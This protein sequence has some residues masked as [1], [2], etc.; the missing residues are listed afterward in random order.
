MSLIDILLFIGLCT[1]VQA[2]ILRLWMD[3]YVF[4]KVQ[5]FCKWMRD[6]TKVL[7]LVGYLL[8]CWQCFGT[9]VGWFVVWALASFMP[10]APISA[11]DWVLIFLFG[12]AVGFL[13]DLLEYYVISPL[14]NLF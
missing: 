11:D 5:K 12:I 7:H 1:I 3:S 8:T 13:S 10:C 4:S 9:W 2:G 6:S 14:T